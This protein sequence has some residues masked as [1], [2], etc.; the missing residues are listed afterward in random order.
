MRPL[1]EDL[2]E[3][4]D[5]EEVKRELDRELH[6]L[7]EALRDTAPFRTG[8][9]KGTSYAVSYS[10]FEGDWHG[11]IAFPMPYAPY[12]MNRKPNEYDQL[13]SDWEPKFREVM[14]K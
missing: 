12:V 5:I 2:R 7:H 8:A 11:V 3:R 9:L 14:E 10:D 4:F 1:I 6:E 13:F